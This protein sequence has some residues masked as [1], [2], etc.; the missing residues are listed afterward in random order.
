VLD[1]KEKG[2][3]FNKEDNMD[4]Y[5]AA[6]I[7]DTGREA[8]EGPTISTIIVIAVALFWTIGIFFPIYLSHLIL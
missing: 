3:S 1:A 5:Y 8:S 4:V 7:V 2:G 6:R